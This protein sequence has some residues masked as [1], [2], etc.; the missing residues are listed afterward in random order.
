MTRPSLISGTAAIEVFRQLIEHKGV[1]KNKLSELNNDQIHVLL[2]SRHHKNYNYTLENSDP[3][4]FVSVFGSVEKKR[5]L[6][7]TI[8]LLRL[9]LCGSSELL[10]GKW[11]EE[12]VEQILLKTFQFA[13]VTKVCSNKSLD[14]NVKLVHPEQRDDNLPLSSVGIFWNCN[15]TYVNKEHEETAPERS[16]L[17]TILGSSEATESCFIKLGDL[18][19][20]ASPSHFSDCK[21]IRISRDAVAA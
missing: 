5:R 20:S 10:P 7:L 18:E 11:A 17:L 15:I 16:H 3:P 21:E 12:A 4:D 2:N 6:P 9:F 19:E 1:S 13:V 14:L 8:Y